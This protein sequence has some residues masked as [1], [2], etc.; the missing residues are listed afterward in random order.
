MRLRLSARWLLLKQVQSHG[1]DQYRV[2]GPICIN[3]LEQSNTIKKVRAYFTELEGK[4][5]T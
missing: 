2:I 1:L 3:V 5:S 4:P